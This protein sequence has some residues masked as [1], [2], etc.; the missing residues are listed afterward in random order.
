[1]SA[2]G[3]FNTIA[4]YCEASIEENLGSRNVLARGLAMLDRRLGKRRIV[5][6]NMAGEHPLVAE[7]HRVRLDSIGRTKSERL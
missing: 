1:M 7:L 4:A 5:A 2:E 6:L 3:F